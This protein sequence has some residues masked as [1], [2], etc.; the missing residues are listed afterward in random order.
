[1]I[2]FLRK[3]PSAIIAVIIVF[4]VIFI[5]VFAPFIAPYDPIEIKPVIR[6]QPPSRNHLF[7]T[8]NAGRDIFSRVIWGAR[9]SLRIG[10][11]VVTVAM[12]VGTLF[13]MTSGYLGGILDEIMMRIADI[14][15]AFPYL[16]FAMAITAALGR[17][18]ENVT[19]ALAIV[20]WP[21]YS[22][23][24]R[25]RVLE[26]K[27]LDYI[28]AAVAGG[29]GHFV[30]LFKHILPN[31]ISPVIIQGS[32]DFGQAIIFAAGLSFIGLG[33]QPPTP[34]WGAIVTEGSKY[35]RE[36]W[37]Y[38]TFPGLTILITVMGFNMLG[39]ALRDFLDPRLHNV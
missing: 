25:S 22:R 27:E 3:N 1:M 28:E 11:I 30:I 18:I 31:A 5:A 16:V 8:D 20:W 21:A 13:G 34:E 39:E 17:G 24:I 33:V 26:I 10:L 29:A 36:A 6:L 7:G 32:I 2:R 35:M 9:I 23:L 12:I 19:L 14:F 4:G 37:W 38:A 15:L